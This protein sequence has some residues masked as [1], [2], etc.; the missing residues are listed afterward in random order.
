MTYHADVQAAVRLQIDMTDQLAVEKGHGSLDD[1]ATAGRDCGP[2]AVKGIVTRRWGGG[3]L[4]CQQLVVGADLAE[5]KN[6][7]IPDQWGHR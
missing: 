3:K 1:R 2:D 7:A 6:V 5:G 4:F